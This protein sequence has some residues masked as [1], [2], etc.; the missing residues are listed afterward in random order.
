MTTERERERVGNMNQSKAEVKP[1]MKSLY[2][3]TTKI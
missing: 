3:T 1:E 2:E